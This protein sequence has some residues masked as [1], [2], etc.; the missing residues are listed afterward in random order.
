MREFGLNNIGSICYLNSLIQALISCKIFNSEIMSSD[1]RDDSPMLKEFQH[2]LNHINS[3]VSKVETIEPILKEII[4]SH[5]FFG[6][7][8]EDVVEG[9][10]IILNL[11][12]DNIASVFESIW[13]VNIFCSN[14]KLVVSNTTD[15]MRRITMERDYIPYVKK[16]GIDMFVS[17]HMSRFSNYKCS[18]T[19]CDRTDG[20]K[21]SRLIKPPNVMVV[22]FNKYHTKWISE[23][24]KDQMDVVYGKHRTKIAKYKLMA[25]IHHRGSM[26]SGHYTVTAIR[27]GFTF[28]FNDAKILNSEFSQNKNDY[29]L[30]YS[31]IT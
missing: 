12:G 19:Q 13:D 31:R 2:F 28:L 7:Q 9:F 14:C 25:V 30:F 17:G 20:I 5:E 6:H 3:S 16:R 18:S 11:V 29:V 1:S 8:Q 22:S 27:D 10:D 24:H 15:T 23:P 4:K 21:V 26:I